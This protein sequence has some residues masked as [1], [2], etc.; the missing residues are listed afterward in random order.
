MTIERIIVGDERIDFA[1]SAFPF[2]PNAEVEFTESHIELIRRARTRNYGLVVTDLEYT[3][4]GREGF[5]VL[6]SI[7]DINVRKILWTGAAHMQEIQQRARELG[8]ELLSK[9]QI[10]SLVGQVVNNAP[11]KRDGIVLVYVPESNDPLY[12]SIKQVLEI[13]SK[14][15]LVI[16]SNLAREL[17]SGRYGLVIDTTPMTARLTRGCESFNGTVAHDMKYLKLSEVPRV[18]CVYDVCTF[19]AD[20]AKIS[21]AFFAQQK[22][23]N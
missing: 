3:L 21:S 9:E 15:K 8:A 14:D 20:V 18:A 11:L 4:N 6:E 7:Q 16:G 22:T 17:E 12:R 2:I 19:L 5:E 23:G 1:R 13:L 10:G